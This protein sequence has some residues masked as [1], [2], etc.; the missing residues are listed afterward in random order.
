MRTN[1]IVNIENNNKYCFIWSILAN[2][3]P[4]NNNHPNRISNYIQYFDELYI[5]CFH[6][7]YGFKCSDVHNFNDINNLSNNIFKL[8]FNQDQNKWIHKL[9]PIEI[10]KNISDT[11]IDLTIYKNHYIPNKNLDIFRRSLQ[12]IICRQCLSSYTSENMLMKHEKKCGDDNITTIKTS[13]E[14]HF[15]WD[16][17]FHKNPLYF[18]IYADFEADKEKNYSNI[19]NKTT[20][21]YKQKPI[22][23]GYHIESELEGILKSGYHKSPLRY[24]NVDWFV[25]EVVKLEKKIAFYFKSTT[26]DIVITEEDEQDYRINNFCRF[27]EKNIESDKVRDHCHLTGKYRG[28]AHSKCNIN[29]TQDQSNFIPFIFHNFSKYDFHMFFKKIG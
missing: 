23:N 4:C 26:K 8:N 11:K 20:N 25:D 15:Q 29:V 3:H 9:I 16:N 13:N 2:L 7:S 1:A 22:L 10:S 12:K 19:G 17:Y 24:S 5:Q 21:I 28:P 27:S 18:R 14:S 6:F